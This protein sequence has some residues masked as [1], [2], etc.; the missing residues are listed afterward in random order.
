MG[1]FARQ[2]GWLDFGQLIPNIRHRMRLEIFCRVVVRAELRKR[3]FRGNELFL[4][5]HLL[6][7]KS[8]R[9]L[10]SISR[11][12]INTD[13]ASTETAKHYQS[14]SAVQSLAQADVQLL[15]STSD[16]AAAGKNFFDLYGG[17]L[18]PLDVGDVVIVPLKLRNDHCGD[19]ELIKH[20]QRARP[21]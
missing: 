21:V 13:H 19:Y 10:S 18:V 3:C 6:G 7:R 20:G 4:H 17:E 16:F 8:R 9:S 2:L 11:A 1:D 12:V 14:Q 5:S 15:T